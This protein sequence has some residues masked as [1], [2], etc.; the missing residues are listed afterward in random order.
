ME[1]VKTLEVTGNSNGDIGSAICSVKKEDDE[2][3]V[4]T[5]KFLSRA[6]SSAS[7]GVKCIW[8]YN[9]VLIN[10]VLLT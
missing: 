7:I 3:I 9:I 1:V 10:S 8:L 4:S 6:H 2:C 5:I